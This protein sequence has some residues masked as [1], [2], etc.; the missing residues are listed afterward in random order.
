MARQAGDWARKY[1]SCWKLGK[2]LARHVKM[3]EAATMEP[4][5]SLKGLKYALALA[6]SKHHPWHAGE[7]DPEEEE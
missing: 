4:P 7:E 6:V 1:G 5:G 3:L 2:L